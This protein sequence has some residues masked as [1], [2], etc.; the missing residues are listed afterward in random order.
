MCFINHVKETSWNFVTFQ[1]LLYL[2]FKRSWWF[3]VE[4]N[5]TMLE[6]ENTSLT[7]ARIN[8][9]IFCL[10]IIWTIIQVSYTFK[11]VIIWTLIIIWFS[12][13]YFLVQFGLSILDNTI[14]VV[15]SMVFRFW[16][17]NSCSRT[18]LKLCMKH[19][20]LWSQVSRNRCL[21]E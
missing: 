21:S 11:L 13:L 17:Y 7:L 2:S 9:I 4:S 8:P 18:A 10:I 6:I 3:Q 15:G 19:V 14:A 1:C 20:E 12:L 16:I 5:W